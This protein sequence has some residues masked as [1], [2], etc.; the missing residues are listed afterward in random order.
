MARLIHSALKQ[1][2]VNEAFL[3]LSGLPIRHFNAQA[4]LA[5][6]GFPEIEREIFRRGG[7]IGVALDDQSGGGFG[8]AAEESKE[9]LRAALFLFAQQ[10]GVFNHKR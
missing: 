8:A 2:K 7:R 4:E 1:C 9:F 3:L 5:F 10:G 6:A